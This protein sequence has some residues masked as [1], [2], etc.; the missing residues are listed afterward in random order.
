MALARGLRGLGIDRT[1][2][3]SAGVL[4]ERVDSRARAPIVAAYL[5]SVG[6]LLASRVREFADETDNLLGGLLLARGERLYVDYFSS[7]MPFAYYLAAVPALFGASTLEQ[8]RVF[9]NMLLVL[10]T[11]LM[12]WAFRHSLPSVLLGIWATLAVFAHTLQWGEMLTA[13]TIAA[14]GVLAAGL[15][16]FTTPGLHFS[17]ARLLGL[18]AA[19]FVAIQS[20]LLAVFPLLL[21]A[22]CLI[23]V[24]L[25]QIRRGLVSVAACVRS[26]AGAL[27]VVAAPH[28]LVL[29]GFYLTGI[30]PDFAFDAYQFNQADYS[31]F[32]MNPTVA[33]MLHDWEAQYRTYLLLSL[34]APL[35]IEACL[36]LGNFMAAWIVFRSRGVL[37]AALYY[38]FVALTHVRNEGAYY[39]CSYFSLALD[40]TWALGAL[41]LSGVGWQRVVAAIA[42]LESL[43][44]V[45]QV[46]GTYDLSRRSVDSPDAA[47]VRAVTAPGEKIF[48]APYDPF[49]YLAADRMPAGRY[50]FYFPWQAIDPRSEGTLMSDLRAEQPPVVIF[51]R[52]ELVNG[53]WR[54]GEYG[55]RLYE[56]LAEQGYQPV[57]ASS[58]A[59]EH[60]LVR[61]DRL[62]GA[63][64]Q[65]QIGASRPQPLQPRS[66]ENQ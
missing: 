24:R 17:L 23:G 16:F 27:L 11:L 18:S 51:R 35:G 28:A 36:I 14:F 7:H 26:A 41:R 1:R 4:L 55:A 43:D 29:L 40:I 46:A 19:V 5:V 57:D 34:Q 37:I 8:F 21:L 20:E 66:A 61:Q 54:V 22:V 50:P 32:V 53:Q 63:R 56:F 25:V 12:V 10:V 65:L 42:L 58:A 6:L 30:L 49:V 62:A 15:I 45:V 59:L 60:V 9:S 3:T 38:A 31:Q 47:I 39:L 33:G 44:F 2:S 13:G 52:D 64:E 48:V